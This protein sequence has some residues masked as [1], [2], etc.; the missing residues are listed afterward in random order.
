[1]G[2]MASLSAEERLRLVD[3]Y[4]R[5][6]SL[7]VLSEEFGLSP[8]QIQSIVMQLRGRVARPVNR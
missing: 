7:A 4:F 5:G 3:A 8:S 6:I 2:G 1:M